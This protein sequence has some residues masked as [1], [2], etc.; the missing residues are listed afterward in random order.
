MSKLAS[1]AEA[2]LF[3][4]L[5]Q[6]LCEAKSFPS[7]NLFPQMRSQLWS[8]AVISTEKP[9]GRVLDLRKEL[10]TSLRRSL[11]R[12]RFLILFAPLPLHHVHLLFCRSLRYHF[13]PTPPTNRPP[14]LLYSSITSSAIASLPAYD[15]SLLSA[16]RRQ[17]QSDGVALRRS[18]TRH[19]RRC[20]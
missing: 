5:Y 14:T 2:E 3:P 18:L 15:Q 13:H 12:R 20:G 19:Q 1:D 9:R 11:P 8:F 6:F 17:H 4:F 7:E 16:L 10:R